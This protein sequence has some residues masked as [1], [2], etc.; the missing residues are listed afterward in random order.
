MGNW[1]F[2]DNELFWWGS[3]TFTATDDY[4]LFIDVIILTSNNLAKI[5]L[6][7]LIYGNL[8]KIYN[9]FEEGMKE[10][11][12]IE[13]IKTKNDLL[14]NKNKI[15][16]KTDMAKGIAITFIRLIAEKY[17]KSLNSVI[18]KIDPNHMYLCDRFPG[19]IPFFANIIEKYC[20]IITI[21]YY[22]IFNPYSGTNNYINQDLNGFNEKIRNKPLYITEWS[23]AALDVG[24]PSINGAGL[25]VISQEQR[26]HSIQVLQLLYSAKKYI[27]GSD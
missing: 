25:R 14:E 23:V 13:N 20:D 11:F 26:A 4:G 21:N 6:V 12:Q 19:K 8:T 17:Y 7:D 5:E 22:P 24:L 3:N 16:P 18:Y 1:P 2:F 15:E 27:V 9:T 10:V